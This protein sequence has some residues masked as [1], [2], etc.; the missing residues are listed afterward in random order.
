[1]ADPSAP[2]AA[3][4]KEAFTQGEALFEKG[5]YGPAIYEFRRADELR[6][7]P[8]VAFNLAKCHEKLGDTAFSTYYYRLYLKR[9]PTASDALDVAGKVGAE[10]AS[11]EAEGRGLLE[12]TAPGALEVSV[13]GRTYVDGLV[14]AFLPP[15]DYELEA[16]FASGK[17]TRSVQLLTGKVTEVSFEPFP[18]P[19]LSQEQALAQQLLA[20]RERSAKVRTGAYVAWGVSVAA[21]LAGTVLGAM[22]QA[23]AGRLSGD[24]AHLTYPQA[25]GLADSANQ[26][27]LWAN[28]LWLGGG[29]GV[30]AAGVLFAFG[31]PEPEKAAAP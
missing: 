1:M 2:Q 7:T 18:P 30:L 26:K 22:A 9:A 20:R 29:A 17:R 15:G 6:P 21:L 11:A 19:L 27:G 4:F 23:D 5:E 12:L 16:S 8:E 31:M 28:A 3:R 10:L 25:Q 14:A 13:G 24:R